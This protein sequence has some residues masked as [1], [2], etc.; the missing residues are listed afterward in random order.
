MQKADTK[1]LHREFDQV[2]GLIAELD[3]GKYHGDPDKPIQDFNEILNTVAYGVI[4]DSDQI[5]ILR[6]G[7]DYLMRTEPEAPHGSIE[8]AM[9]AVIERAQDGLGNALDSALLALVRHRLKGHSI[10]PLNA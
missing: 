7:I 9:D 3:A 5:Q 10:D 2:M 1:T 8:D 6:K 4:E